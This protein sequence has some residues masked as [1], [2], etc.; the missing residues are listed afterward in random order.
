MFDTQNAQVVSSNPGGEARI[1]KTPGVCG[2]DACIRGTR[3]MVWLLVLMKRDG[4]EEE[5][6][7]SNFPDLSRADLA[8]AWEYDRL[9][10]EEIKDA[11]AANQTDEE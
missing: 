9:H 2:G 3:I 7:L 8:A 1:Q 4:L 6:I 11:I 10:P 5:R